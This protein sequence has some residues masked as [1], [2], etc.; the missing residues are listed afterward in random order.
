MQSRVKTKGKW[1]TIDHK[2]IVKKPKTET[3]D[4]KP[5]DTKD[6]TK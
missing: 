5:K 1:E 4:D 2:P 6:V 3:K